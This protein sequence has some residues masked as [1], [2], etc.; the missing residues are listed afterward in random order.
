MNNLLSSDDRK[1]LPSKVRRD[2]VNNYT[3]YETCECYEYWKKRLS[4]IE[5]DIIQTKERRTRLYKPLPEDWVDIQE[6]L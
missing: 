4:K 3:V 5:K 2:V 1:H 6:N